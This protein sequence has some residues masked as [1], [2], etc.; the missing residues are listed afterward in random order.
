[1]VLATWFLTFLSL[2]HRTAHF[3]VARSNGSVSD[4]D[5]RG[6]RMVKGDL[7]AGMGP[8]IDMCAHRW[9]DVP[10]PSGFISAL[11]RVL[12]LYAKQR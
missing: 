3:F 4:G 1:M 12:L 10:P 5:E 9:V 2:S 7:D 6:E 8:L 11:G